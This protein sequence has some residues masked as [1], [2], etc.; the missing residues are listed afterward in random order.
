MARIT[1]LSNK[2]LLEIAFWLSTGL[3][4]DIRA[5]LRLCYTSRML[6]DVA[7]PALYTRVRMTEYAPD[8]LANL[9]LFLW[10]LL[11]Y[12]SSAQKTKELALFNDRRFRY[13]WPALGQD[14]VFMN[15]SAFIGGH[16]SEIEPELSYYPLAVQVLARLPNLQHLHS[17]AQIE[18]PR[19]LMQRIHEMQV[20]FSILSKLKT[21]HL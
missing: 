16:P 10:T 20:E 17:T 21:F 14:A 19:S 4:C 5:L 1:D 13:V 2:L 11:D 9:K 15:L 3:E 6:Y 7:Q 18:A 12:P 8:S